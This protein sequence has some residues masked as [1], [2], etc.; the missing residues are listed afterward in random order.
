MLNLNEISKRADKLIKKITKKDFEKWIF[1]DDK[2]AKNIVVQANVNESLPNH[3]CRD[4]G[5][6]LE[7]DNIYGQ[8]TECYFG[9][10][11]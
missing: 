5:T 2:R 11:H 9:N 6:P 3:K 7:E 4:C 10:V 8:C 1:F